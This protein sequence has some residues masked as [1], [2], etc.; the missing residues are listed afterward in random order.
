MHNVIVDRSLHTSILFLHDGAF[1]AQ[2]CCVCRLFDPWILS[3]FSLSGSSASFFPC[4]ESKETFDRDGGSSFLLTAP[5]FSVFK[6]TL[7]TQQK[8]PQCPV[9]S[10]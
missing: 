4:V 8:H 10:Q 2:T 3:S 6:E 1:S 5:S 9:I 7:S